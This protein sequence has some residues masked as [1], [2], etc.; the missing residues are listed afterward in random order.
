VNEVLI[1][2]DELLPDDCLVLRGSQMAGG[3]L[4]ANFLQV[5][6][7]TAT[8]DHPEGLDAI[9]VGVGSGSVAQVAQ[10]MPYRGRWVRRST[11]WRLNEAGY[12]VFRIDD[13][14][15]PAHAVLLLGAEPNGPDW[16]G[17]LALAELFD[18]PELNPHHSE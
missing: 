5:K 4:W 7:E 8:G 1:R 3:T 12:Q 15:Y 11:L 9:C 10:Q 17:W 13:D 14:D 16:G 18:S 6:A 2:W